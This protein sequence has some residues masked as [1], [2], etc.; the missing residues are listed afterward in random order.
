MYMFELTKEVEKVIP[1]LLLWLVCFLKCNHLLKQLLTSILCCLR[2]LSAGV[3]TE[4]DVVC[5][6]LVK[7][8]KL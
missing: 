2:R 7:R 3:R 6:A 5:M 4:L 8:S 1:S